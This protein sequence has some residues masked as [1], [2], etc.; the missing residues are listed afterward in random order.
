MNYDHILEGGTAQFQEERGLQPSGVMQMAEMAESFIR[1]RYGHKLDFSDKLLF[2]SV[3]PTIKVRSTDTERT[4]DS[5]WAQYAQL[6]LGNKN[7]IPF[8]ATDYGQ[9]KKQDFIQHVLET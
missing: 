3:D 1:P 9:S 2:T 4:I 5:A 7:E 8:A 6:Y